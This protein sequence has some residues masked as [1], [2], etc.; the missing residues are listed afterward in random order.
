[1]RAFILPS[2][3]AL[4]GIASIGSLHL[5]RD[6]A[7]VAHVDQ[8]LASAANV[9]KVWAEHDAGCGTATPIGNRH[10]VWIFLSCQ[11]VA[12]MPAT[13]VE[14]QGRRLSIARTESLAQRDLA[15]LFVVGDGHPVDLVSLAGRAAVFGEKV[16]AVGYG[17]GNLSL[18]EGR[19]SERGK[20]STPII[21]GNSGGPLLDAD[22]RILG[23]MVRVMTNGFS[24]VCHQAEFEPLDG[25]ELSWIREQ[26]GL[27]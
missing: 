23:V 6:P 15:V 4:V 22:G 20:C 27:Q 12:D 19:V 26:A 3:V 21:F 11:H 17:L 8:Q 13:S 10:G 16:M 9:W 5:F 18:T 25:Y 14:F 7:A 24:V 2:F 1:M